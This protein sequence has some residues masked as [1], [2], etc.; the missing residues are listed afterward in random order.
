MKTTANIATHKGRELTLP[1]MIASI[2]DQVDEIR[3]YCNDFMEF[4]VNDPDGKIIVMFGIKD[5]TDNA[6]FYFLS[7]RPEFY[8]M[9]DDDLVYPPD[10]VDRMKQWLIQNPDTVVTH[11]GRILTGAGQRYYRGGHREL[12][13]LGEVKQIERIDVCGTGV[14]A[15]RTDYINPQGLHEDE[16]QLMSDLIF[17]ECMA[18]NGVEIYC[19]DHSYGYFKYLEPPKGTTI[20]ERF[21]GNDISLQNS[22]ADNIYTILHGN[23]ES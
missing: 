19:L 12:R 17:S 15:F 16:R 6:K 21:A 9:M 8:F 5:Y 11:H 1:R 20:Y 13:C 10:Y 14:T 7:D 23:Q 3:V 22:I 4:Q 2:Y 18:Y